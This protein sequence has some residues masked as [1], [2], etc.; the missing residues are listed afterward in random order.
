M[1]AKFSEKM[2]ARLRK[3]RNQEGMTLEELADGTGFAMTTFS[4]VENGHDAPSP[5][6]LEA[7]IRRL[8][9]NPQWLAEGKGR[10]FE[11][12]RMLVMIP[13]SHLMSAKARARSLRDQASSLIQEAEQLE[14]EI[15]ESED[16]HRENGRLPEGYPSRDLGNANKK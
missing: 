11:R 1:Q 7:W 2:R 8:R 12:S 3:A 14:Y 16:Y 5:R 13:P 4:S 6:L 15:R 9:L 10:I